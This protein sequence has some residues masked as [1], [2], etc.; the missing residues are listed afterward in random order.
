LTQQKTR[1]DR[2]AIASVGIRPVI[3]VML[4]QDRGSKM[5]EALIAICFCLAADSPSSQSSRREPTAT[6]RKLADAWLAE[7][8]TMLSEIPAKDQSPEARK[9]WIAATSGDIPPPFIE[10]PLTIGAVGT[11]SGGTFRLIHRLGKSEGRVAIQKPTRGRE[12]GRAGRVKP[13]KPPE[14]VVLLRGFDM[15][16]LAD[17]QDCK[18]TRC[19]T[20]TGRETYSSTLGGSRTLFVI[21]PYDA[22]AAEG[23]F[24]KAVMQELDSQ[25][26]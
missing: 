1:L 14:V 4:T 13:K 12:A 5:A 18:V 8:R 24:R 6:D 2:I 11:L 19:F 22:S 10:H 25:R 7:R 3:V 23:L 9:R 26:D 21:E 16:S 15:S 17:G 20:V